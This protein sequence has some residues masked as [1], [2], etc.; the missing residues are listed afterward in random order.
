MSKFIPLNSI[1]IDNQE[2]KYLLHNFLFWSWSCDSW[3]SETFIESDMLLK[4]E[5]FVR[6][7]IFIVPEGHRYYSKNFWSEAYGLNET[8]FLVKLWLGQ[9]GFWNSKLSSYIYD[10][11]HSY[12]PQDFR[13]EAYG[14]NKSHFLVFWNY[15]WNLKEPLRTRLKPTFRFIIF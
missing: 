13:S 7:M 15:S 14:L 4:P 1:F 6:H 8:H 12:Y 11:Y 2:G 10:F 9:T 3:V 5:I